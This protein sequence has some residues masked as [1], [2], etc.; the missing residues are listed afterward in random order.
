MACLACG[1][2]RDTG[3]VGVCPSCRGP[4]PRIGRATTAAEALYALL[5]ADDQALE[6]RARAAWV[7]A[8][9]EAVPL[10]EAERRWLALGHAARATYRAAALEAARL[11]AG[12][13]VPPSKPVPLVVVR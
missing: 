13:P 12:V 8:L 1:L 9:G 5:E 3:R 6:V 7:R 2:E 11:A 10:P 4:I